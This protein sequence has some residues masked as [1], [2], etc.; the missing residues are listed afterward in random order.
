VIRNA[1]PA[2]R[3]VPIGLVAL[4]A[5][6]AVA[7]AAGGGAAA[8]PRASAAPAS[9]AP[10]SAAPASA[11][12]ASAAPAPAPAW[13]VPLPAVASSGQ[14]TRVVPVACG[15]ASRNRGA[16]RTP[17]SDALKNAF[18][19]LRRERTDEDAL[20][21]AALRALKAQGRAPVDAQS[22]RLL[23][24]DGAARAWVVPVPDVGEATALG[25]LRGPAARKPREGIAVVSLGGAPAGGGGALRDL[26]RGRAPA[27]LD[28]C[29]GAGRNML[30]VSGIVPDGVEA[31]F[32]TGAD[33]TSTRADVRD[34]GYVF[35]L[36]R[37]PRPEQRFI[38]WTGSD[39]SPHVQPLPLIPLGGG[40]PCAR[41]A[42]AARVTPDPW[43][44]WCLPY[45][46]RPVVVAP[47]P[48]GARSRSASRAARRRQLKRGARPRRPL[49][50]CILPSPWPG[51]LAPPQPP[52]FAPPPQGPVPQPGP[53]RP[54][55]LP[56]PAPVPV[57][58]PARPAVPS[59]APVPVPARP[60][61]PSRAPI[62]PRP[63]P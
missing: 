54:G 17:P 25:C 16:A 46:V 40:V 57:P 4:A 52:V 61:V 42:A 10:A 35:V 14:A 45:S 8:T 55:V 13:A 9:A 56:A 2:R 15:P 27:A 51:Q 33:G 49:S 36:P 24:A 63:G 5:G 23:R 19:I 41:V 7:Q 26:Q 47:R 48:R 11:A 20:P 50:A 21:A 60:A 30:G 6:A 1:L 53:Q 37:P 44:A 58:V 39:G 28:A 32:V 43:G 3:L 59:R 18:A 62:E 29:A 34:N 38:V 31:V 12:P 22:A